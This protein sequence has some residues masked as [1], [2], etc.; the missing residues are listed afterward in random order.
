MID[1]KIYM[2]E[3]EVIEMSDILVLMEIYDPE[4]PTLEGTS[5][6]NEVE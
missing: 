6:Y 1:D 3:N 2:M 5:K 4:C